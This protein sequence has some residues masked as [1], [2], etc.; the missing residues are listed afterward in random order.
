MDP[1]QLR[2]PFTDENQLRT[3]YYIGGTPLGPKFINSRSKGRGPQKSQ[4]I[5]FLLAFSFI[6]FILSVSCHC[7]QQQEMADFD[8]L[9]VK[10]RGVT[11]ESTLW[12]PIACRSFH[13][14]H[15][16]KN[17][18]TGSGIGI[19][20][21]TKPWISFQP[22]FCSNQL[23]WRSLPKESQKLNEITKKIYCGGTF[24]KKRP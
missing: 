18:K 16:P 24:L 7:A 19:F 2:N 3:S 20:S 21:L 14:V 5:N 11:H 23:K 13:G 17:L 9:Y 1:L 15:F 6:I 22:D 12:G 8:V 4:H 10:R